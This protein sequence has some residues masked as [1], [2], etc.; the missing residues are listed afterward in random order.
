MQLVTDL[1]KYGSVLLLVAYHMTTTTSNNT[2]K[3]D[4][5]TTLYRGPVKMEWRNGQRVQVIDYDALSDPVAASAVS[6][7]SYVYKKTLEDVI[8]STD[9]FQYD[10][11][12][13]DTER[14]AFI[15]NMITGIDINKYP[16]FDHEIGNGG[17]Y[18]ERDFRSLDTILQTL[19]NNKKI[20]LDSESGNL[21]HFKY[22]VDNNL[23]RMKCNYC[24]TIINTG[25][26]G[27]TRHLWSH[28]QAR[29]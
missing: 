4:N 22:A 24:S 26:E 21:Y 19:V 5:D 7:P 3:N 9:K 18:V 20:F 2:T 27:L 15:R 25:P 1:A 13:S 10:R 29:R 14:Y 16:L 17:T 12:K 8:S 28:Q 23:A 11:L 6:S